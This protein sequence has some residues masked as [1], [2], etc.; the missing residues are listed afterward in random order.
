[1]PG[2]YVLKKSAV[3]VIGRDYLDSLNSNASATLSASAESINDARSDTSSNSD[4]GTGGVV[5][6]YVVG[7]EEQ[8]SMTPSDV[9]VT[10]TQDMLTGGQTKRLVKQIAMGAI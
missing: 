7:Q 6:V 10:I 8:Q 3:D 4:K 9:L 2:E 5:N 1:M